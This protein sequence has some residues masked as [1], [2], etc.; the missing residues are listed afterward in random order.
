MIESTKNGTALASGLGW[1]SIGL[2]AA[3]LAA[4]AMLAKLIGARN[5]TTARTT[6]R[7]YGVRELIAGIAILAGPRRSLP[8]WNR[9]VGDVID[10][11]TIGLAARAKKCD[12]GRLF[13][14]AAGVA[15]VMA[16]DIFAAVKAMRS[17]QQAR[18]PVIESITINRPVGEV[19]AAWRD[20]EQLPQFMDW[21]ESVRDIGGGL[22]H[23]VAKLPVGGTVEWTA[24]LVE[25]IPNERISWRTIDK[26]KVPHKGTVWFV[27]TLDGRGTEIH[28][29]MQYDVPGSRRLGA[30]AA[31]L[32]TKGQVEGDL[33]RFKQVLETGE[34]VRSDASIHRGPHPARPSEKE[35]SL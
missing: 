32:A 25:D 11:A 20:F 8:L 23:W 27:P 22:S 34:V 24:V 6:L 30:F 17:Q 26:A 18:V 4:P 12:R 7:A 19:Y 35:L 21:L 2:G 28:V 15:G 10:L 31:K 29:E 9:V 5:T 33:R 3:E 14:S 16:I 13:A 1:F